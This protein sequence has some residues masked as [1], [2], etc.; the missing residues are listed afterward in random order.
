MDNEDDYSEDLDFS[1]KSAISE[2]EDEINYSSIRTYQK[3]TNENMD[4]DIKISTKKSKKSVDSVSS[5]VATIITT[6]SS[7]SSVIYNSKTS[8]GQTENVRMK[9][10]KRYRNLKKRKKIIRMKNR[11]Y[12]V[13][14]KSRNVKSKRNCDQNQEHVLRQKSAEN[15]N[16]AH[17]EENQ[18]FDFPTKVNNM[19]HS[20]SLRDPRFE[21]V[22]AATDRLEDGFYHRSFLPVSNEIYARPTYFHFVPFIP[23]GHFYHGN[24]HCVHYNPLKIVNGNGYH[25]INPR[26]SSS[27]SDGL[28]W[29]T[30]NGRKLMANDLSQKE[31][32]RDIVSDIINGGKSKEPKESMTK[33][34]ESDYGE[35]PDLSEGQTIKKHSKLKKYNKVEAPGK[36]FEDNYEFEESP[37]E[38]SNPREFMEDQIGKNIGKNSKWEEEDEEPYRHSFRDKLTKLKHKLFNKENDEI[39]GAMQNQRSHSVSS[40]NKKRIERH[41]ESGGAVA[42]EELLNPIIGVT[43]NINFVP[44]PIGDPHFCPDDTSS[45]GSSDS[46]PRNRKCPTCRW[47]FNPMSG[48]FEATPCPC[49]PCEPPPCPNPWETPPPCPCPTPCN[50]C[51]AVTESN[52]HAFTVDVRSPNSELNSN[53]PCTD[54]CPCPKPEPCCGTTCPCPPPSPPPCPPPSP[55]PCP[56]D[57]CSCPNPC[58]CPCP[59]SVPSSEE[60][61]KLSENQ[62]NLGLVEPANSENDEMRMSNINSL[63]G[64]Q[65]PYPLSEHYTAN[66]PRIQFRQYP[67]QCMFLPNDIYKV[68]NSPKSEK[69]GETNDE[70]S[71]SSYDDSS[72]ENINKCPYPKNNQVY[73]YSSDPNYREFLEKSSI[74]DDDSNFNTQNL[75]E[76]HVPSFNFPHYCPCPQTPPT[77]YPYMIHHACPRPHIAGGFQILSPSLAKRHIVLGAEQPERAFGSSDRCP[78]V[79]GYF[80]PCPHLTPSLNQ[81]PHLYHSPH[82]VNDADE[83]HEISNNGVSWIRPEGSP[84]IRDGFSQPL[85]FPS[86]DNLR[87]KNSYIACRPSISLE[88]IFSPQP[89]SVNLQNGPFDSQNVEDNNFDDSI[90]DATYNDKRTL[91]RKVHSN[92]PRSFDKIPP[93]YFEKLQGPNNAAERLSDV[94]SLPYPEHVFDD[95]NPYESYENRL[96][97]NSIK[98]TEN[99]LKEKRRCP[100]PTEP[101]PPCTGCPPSYSERKLNMKN[102]ILAEK[103]RMVNEYLKSKFLNGQYSMNSMFPRSK[104]QLT[105]SKNYPNSVDDSMAPSVRRVRRPHGVPRKPLNR[106]MP[107]QLDNKK[108]KTKYTKSDDEDLQ[109]DS[110][111]PY[112]INEEDQVQEE[113]SY[114]RMQLDRKSRSFLNEESH[115]N[116]MKSE[117]GNTIKKKNR[118]EL[119][120]LRFAKEIIDSVIEKVNKNPN[121]K[122][123]IG[124]A[125]NKKKIY[126]AE[127]NQQNHAKECNSKEQ[128]DYEETRN[129]LRSVSCVLNKLVKKQIQEKL[130]EHLPNHLK[131]FLKHIVKPPKHRIK[132]RSNDKYHE[133]TFLFRA[134]YPQK[135]L[136]M[137]CKNRLEDNLMNLL[138]H[139]DQL[140]EESKKKA[141]PVQ[142]YI[143]NHLN[144]L[145][146]IEDEQAS[147][148]DSLGG[149]EN[150][151]NTNEHPSLNTLNEEKSNAFQNPVKFE[152]AQNNLDISP[153]DLENSDLEQEQN[154]FEKVALHDRA[155]T[156]SN[157][158]EV[159]TKLKKR[160]AIDD[161]YKSDIKK[162]EVKQNG[163]NDK[164][165]V[166]DKYKKLV[167][168]AEEVRCKRKNEEKIG[169]AFGKKDVKRNIEST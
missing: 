37:N 85:S 32:K 50:P 55:P 137:K 20:K 9:R 11:L 94:F 76:T 15:P 21:K 8:T 75:Y 57:P 61:D 22:N 52:D 27:N 157:E 24:I 49:D 96:E 38:N 151:L 98:M 167:E 110:S 45:Q 29:N 88:K 19:K 140:D 87:E 62:N 119:Q 131:N 90:N 123:K 14:D 54:D 64:D 78:C 40:D 161:N 82:V 12:P 149:H 83:I 81:H 127:S 153:R 18:W 101:L 41:Q 106:K 133:D 99:E 118:I 69:L 138:N 31:H 136:N 125:L 26:S 97:K 1:T 36:N 114:P 116:H 5:K 128:E 148:K 142:N 121:L 95:S 109:A 105:S 146:K 60:K 132:Q 135:K 67:R 70:N 47:R 100:K 33:R 159:D 42:R 89:E 86:E 63:S 111:I 139:Y 113:E 107:E 124:N 59:C 46:F 112:S 104:R 122:I 130:C 71:F 117:N 48:T 144:M 150:F 165:K 147:R 53:S 145:K 65:F 7:D 43:P 120:D 35:E 154:S 92:L 129:L 16:Q 6:A 156:K 25:F 66:F 168:A 160:D 13:L 39:D 68:Y 141:A 166:S 108:D 77:Y 44:V 93:N 58:P 155:L 3:S 84:S 164:K 28:S 10:A 126:E 91:S 72:N 163:K 169:E 79:F 80:L 74:Q 34:T 158:E 162:K 56:C 23:P 115:H 73:P 152:G 30:F 134:A 4:N 17:S 103:A 2:S 143:V 51:P 102:D